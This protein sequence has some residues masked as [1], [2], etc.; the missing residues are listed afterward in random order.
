M[1]HAQLAA[2]DLHAPSNYL[3]ENDTGVDIPALKVVTFNGIGTNFPSIEVVTSPAQPV[4]GVTAMDI[5]ALA[6]SNTGYIT[7]L[8]FLI[9]VNTSPWTEGT[10]LYSDSSGNLTTVVLGP[11]VATVY[12]QDAVNGYLFIEDVSQASGGG[13]SGDVI[14]PGSS[15]NMA[16]AAWNGTTGTVLENSPFSIVQPGGAIQAQG[17]VFNTQ[18]LNDIT[19]PDQYAMVGSDVKLISG[20]I[21][22]FGDAQ[23][24]LV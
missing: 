9:N 18:I 4:R 23:L 12:K 6:G 13:G 22:L 15:T 1:L 24:I 5:P 16:I 17:F 7:G 10:R 11:L 3:V 20:D 19:I 2:L 21:I 14:G 8:G